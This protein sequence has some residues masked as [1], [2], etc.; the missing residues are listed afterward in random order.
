M[1]HW[2]RHA[3]GTQRPP[4]VRSKTLHPPPSH[5]VALPLHPPLQPRQQQGRAPPAAR[6]RAVR[7]PCRCS[8]PLR[9][10]ACRARSRRST[11]GRFWALGRTSR[12]TTLALGTRPTSSGAPRSPSSRGSIT[13][14]PGHGRG[15]GWRGGRLA[16]GGGGE[17]EEGGRKGAE[18][19]SRR[20]ALPSVLCCALRPD[21]WPSHAIV[22]AAQHSTAPH[23]TAP[24]R[25]APHRTAPH[26]T[27]PHR[28]IP[29]HP[30]PPHPPHATLCPPHSP[31]PRPAPAATPSR[32]STT[33]PRRSRCGARRC[34][35]S[36]GSSPHLRAA[37]SCG[38]SPSSTSGTAP[39][40]PSACWLGAGAR[41]RAGSAF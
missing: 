29:P 41:W 6:L 4:T 27:A 33:P 1:G 10:P 30:T 31:R 35:S 32:A 39:P 13:C 7:P 36:S 8:R 17:V 14:E 9:R 16:R 15:R 22:V 5:A 12:R 24:H 23:R 19:Y 26:C 18:Q 40:A 25:T 21:S 3:G 28:P 37:N 38:P 11:M 34:V 2:R 20:A